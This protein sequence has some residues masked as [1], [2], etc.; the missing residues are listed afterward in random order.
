MNRETFRVTFQPEGRS[1][2]VLGGTKLVEAAGQGGIILNQPCGGEG[3]CGKC[4]VEVLDNAP[5]PTSADRGHFSEQELA[6]GLPR[7]RAAN[8]PSNPTCAR[9]A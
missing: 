8:T 9:N 6:D 7:A 3:T 2:F 5:E 4:R 1:V